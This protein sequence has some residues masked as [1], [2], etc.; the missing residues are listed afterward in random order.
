MSTT[1]LTTRFPEVGKLLAADRGSAAFATDVLLKSFGGVSLTSVAACVLI[2]ASA[3]LASPD[4]D[5]VEL[6]LTAVAA[7]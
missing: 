4:M 5:T 6:W 3:A 1:D 2:A 7:G